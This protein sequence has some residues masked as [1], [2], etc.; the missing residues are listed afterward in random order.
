MKT[1]VLFLF[2]IAFSFIQLTVLAQAVPAQEKIKALSP[3]PGL[4]SFKIDY[5]YSPFKINDENVNI[6]QVN[7]ALTL[8]LYSKL[9]KGKLDFLVIGFGY[10]GFFL[11]NSSS[12]AE[13][14]FHSVSVPLTFQKAFSPKYALIISFIPMLASDLKVISAEDMTYTAAAM[15]KIRRSEMFSYSFGAAFSGQFFGTVLLP[16][17]GIDWSPNKKLNFSGTLPVF[18]KVKYKLS[19]NGVVGIGHEYRLIGG[20]YGLS[21]KINPAYFQAQQSKVQLFYIYAFTKN[22]SIEANAG[23]NYIQKLGYYDKNQKVDLIPFRDID[24]RTP[25]ALSQKASVAIGVGL[26]YKF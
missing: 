13:G 15:L 17:V 19:E 24:K 11:S 16:L 18:A 21:N 12:L 1:K 6:Q 22:L 23:Y 5:S 2:A 9:E 3:V 8:P 7:T 4:S 14:N 26:N 10:S 25:L 20:A